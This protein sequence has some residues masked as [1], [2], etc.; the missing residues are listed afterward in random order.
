MDA[1]HTSRHTLNV[2]DAEVLLAQAPLPTTM[3]SPW[4][5]S[6]PHQDTLIHLNSSWPA[7]PS[8]LRALGESVPR[9]A[10]PGSRGFPLGVHRPWL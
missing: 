8:Q 9:L 5:V 3:Q 4:T 6:F 7:C 10:V 1:Q 2:S